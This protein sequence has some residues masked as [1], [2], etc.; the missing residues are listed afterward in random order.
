MTPAAP[1][2]VLA[3]RHAGWAKALA[4]A[5]GRARVRPDTVSVASVGFAL[6]AGV[7]FLL[8]PSLTPGR[9]A[10]AL[11]AAAA[12]IQLRLLCNMLD[13]ML[14]VEEGLK[15]RTGDV[16]NELPDRV[17][18]VVILVGAGYSIQFLPGGVTLGWA[19]AVAALLTAYVRALGGSL[20]LTQYFIGP[21]AKQHRM[22]TLTLAAVVSAVEAI[23]GAPPR[24]MPIALAAIVVGSMATAWR[25]TARIMRELDAP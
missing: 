8:V 23:A 18:D 11:L 7:A 3:T 14:A 13:G 1:R 22:F 5:L 6:I 19:A 25:R 12:A 16:Y 24:A 20:G 21:M 10:T 9:Q 15:T 2:R 17:A 4:H